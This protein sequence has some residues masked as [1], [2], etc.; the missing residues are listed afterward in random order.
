MSIVLF[1]ISGSI[2]AFRALEVMRLL[3]GDGNEVIPVL[4]KGGAEFVT[5]HTVEA[6]TGR[7]AVT[8][9]FPEFAQQ[10]IEHVSLAGKADLLVTC[11]ASADILAKYATG[12]SD[13]PLA[14]VALTF[15]TPHIIA[16]AMNYRMW[17]NPANQANV[18]LLVERGCVFVGPDKGKMACGEE[19]WGR[20]S[21][22][23]VIYDHICAELGKNGPLKGK[24]VLVTAGATREPVDDVRYLSNRSSGRMGYA[25]ATAARKL[26]ADVTLVT[27]SELEPPSALE[28]IKIETA[29]EMHDAVL[30]DAGKADVI[31]MTAAVA[32]FAPEKPV[33]G[34]LKKN[35]GLD[36]IKLERTPDILKAL[37]AKKK[38]GQILVGF[39]AEYGTDGKK[40]ALRKCVE[41][42][43][44]MV[45]L[46]DIS[47]K[48]IGFNVDQNEVTI[49]F[50][51]GHEKKLEKT[52][53]ARIARDI[54]LEVAGLKSGSE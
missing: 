32:D 20:L 53:K 24:H 31:I 33:S 1:G 34:K 21:K 12:I 37:G 30:A 42:S 3:V 11:P 43:C 17:A 44:D 51:D 36:S 25:I 9:I 52:M 14:L 22:I 47:R 28:V 4:S 10:E 7:R 46:N 48:D 19:G 8:D 45:C 40:E 15:G 29:K 41:K 49:V 39:A 5:R 54:M 26:G 18:K 38:K 13:D 27:A 2:S 16:P 23:E 6:L 50:P 35:D